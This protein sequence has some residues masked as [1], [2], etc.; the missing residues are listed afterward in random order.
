MQILVGEI[1]GKFLGTDPIKLLKLTLSMR[2]TIFY[3][4]LTNLKNANIRGKK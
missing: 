2:S 4:N 3:T 1:E